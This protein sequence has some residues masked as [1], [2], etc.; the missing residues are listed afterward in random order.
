[1]Q[2]R[3]ADRFDRLRASFSTRTNDR[4]LMSAY[5]GRRRWCLS[6]D[7]W[8]G[9]RLWI[10]LASFCAGT[11]AAKSWFA[12]IV[13]GANAIVGDFALRSLGKFN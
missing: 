6:S 4:A 9:R 1:M 8:R 10:H 2:K 12:A 3:P 11:V 5:Y 7:F 13:I